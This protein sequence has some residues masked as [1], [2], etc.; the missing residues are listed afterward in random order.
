VTPVAASASVLRREAARK[1]VHLTGLAVPAIYYFT[2]QFRAVLILCAFA[3]ASIAIDVVRHRHAATAM[4][5][6]GIF[7]PILR[8][9]ERD[10]QA[11]KL[12]AVSWFF[13]AAVISAALFPK[14]IVI[15]A[16][17]MSLPADAASALVG[18]AWGRHRIGDK[19]LEGSAAFF[20]TALAVMIALPKLG[21]VEREYLIGAMVAVV[22][23]IVELVGVRGADDNLTTPLIMAASMWMS[24]RWLLPQLDLQFGV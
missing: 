3:A 20:L 8:A 17:T 14:Y 9:H 13:V 24:Y 2:P 15:A 1:A 23:T 11:R 4:V 6:N 16:I 12:T 21:H 19:S 22:G 5:F 18:R 7:D 10:R